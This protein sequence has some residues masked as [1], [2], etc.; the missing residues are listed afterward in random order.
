VSGDVVDC[1]LYEYGPR[2]SVHPPRRLQLLQVVEEWLLGY[3]K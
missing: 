2:L 3:R 1:E